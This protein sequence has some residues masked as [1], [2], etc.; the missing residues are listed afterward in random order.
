MEDWTVMLPTTHDIV[1]KQSS[2]ACEASPP[3]PRDAAKEEEDGVQ[4][5]PHD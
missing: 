4:T 5:F 2:S 1:A 3:H